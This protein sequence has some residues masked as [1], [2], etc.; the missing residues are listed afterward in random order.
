MGG[1]TYSWVQE[2]IVGTSHWLLA[3]EIH[4]L[5]ALEGKRLEQH[6]QALKL[7]C[8]KKQLGG[9]VPTFVHDGKVTSV[10]RNLDGCPT[11]VVRLHTVP[12]ILSERAI[13]AL[14]LT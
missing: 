10:A 4:F 8:M 14:C 5:L 1:S 2:I 7:V 3:N 12:L 6:L 11:Y 9:L 13:A